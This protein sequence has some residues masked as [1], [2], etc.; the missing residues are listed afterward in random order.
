M[1]NLITLTCALFLIYTSGIAQELKT[2]KSLKSALEQSSTAKKP[3]LLIVDVI[4]IPKPTNLPPNVKVNFKSGLEDQEV[5]NSINENFVVYKTKM[6]D[7]TI[8]S[9]LGKSNIRSFPAY[10]FLRANK[11]VFFKDFGNSPDKQK[12]TTL[13][14]SALMAFKSESISDLE[15]AFNADKNNNASLV[16]L[17]D[18]RKK[19]GIM[20]NA[21]LIEQYANN[22]KIG[23]FNNYKNVLYIL[24]AGPYS[25]G[26]AYKLAYTNRKIVDSI[27]KTEPVQKR[28]AINNAI[29]SNTMAEA[30]KNKNVA[31]AY[32]G[33]N[34]ARNTWT[35]DY[36]GGEKAYNNQI[37]WYYSTVK[38]T[39]SYLKTASYFYD[40]FY[41]NISADSIKKIEIKEREAFTKTHFPTTNNPVS[42][43]KMDSLKKIPGKVIYTQSVTSFNSS[44]NSYANEL[45]N[46]AWKFYETGTKNLNYLSKAMIWSRRSIEL[47]PIAGY[48]DT[49]AHILYRMGYNEEAIKTQEIAIEKAKSEK[50]QTTQLESE[51][52]KIKAKTL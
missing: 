41:M 21:E 5:I 12:Y 25:D 4:G 3:V 8:R 34:F 42:K 44:S 23:D 9:I 7:T 49:L 39:T 24:E 32:A 33:A 51:L 22:L 10:V 20:N 14:D 36:R 46:A 50:T 29:I 28:V 2:S 52:K 27:Y 26:N 19:V 18:A 30:A 40:S 17:I 35:R 15:T 37:L 45:N 47:K 13:I 16:K 6:T 48:Y 1:K 43:E 31:K 11:E 38:D